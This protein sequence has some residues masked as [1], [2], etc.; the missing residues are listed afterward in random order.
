MNQEQIAVVQECA[1]FSIQGK[2]GFGDVVARFM[3][4]G[5]ER[6]HAD[7]A[8]HETTYYMPDGESFIVAVEHGCRSLSDSR[9]SSNGDSATRRLR[10]T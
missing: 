1:S 7:Y 2:I 6:Y 5:L 3:R 9:R 8:R 10:R 4:I